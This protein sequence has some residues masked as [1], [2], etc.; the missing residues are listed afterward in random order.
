MKIVSEEYCIVSRREIEA[1]DAL[2]AELQGRISAMNE[3]NQGVRMIR[4][5]KRLTKKTPL[6]YSCNGC[7]A[8]DALLDHLEAL[9]QE[10]SDD[11]NEAIESKDR[12]IDELKREVARLNHLV[13]F[14][15]MAATYDKNAVAGFSPKTA[16]NLIEMAADALE[17]GGKISFAAACAVSLKRQM[18]ENTNRF[19]AFE[20]GILDS[21]RI[22]GSIR[23]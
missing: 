20:T 6:D 19:V 18:N 9:I 22:P 13:R 16:R 10:E 23:S 12:E 15:N 4:Y 5:G 8:R 2:I 14:H 7:D 11:Y 17:T 1:K 21:F 3:T